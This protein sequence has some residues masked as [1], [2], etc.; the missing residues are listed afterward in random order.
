MH[1]ADVAPPPRPLPE[2][3]ERRLPVAVHAAAERAGAER[4]RTSGR[5]D[6]FASSLM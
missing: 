5:G 2:Q 3:R 6:P 4:R 1:A